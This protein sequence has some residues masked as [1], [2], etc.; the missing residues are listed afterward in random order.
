[1]AT[2]P[3]PVPDPEPDPTPDPAPT[4]PP[5]GATSPGSENVP[6]G[7][8]EATPDPSGATY[9]MGE[10]STPEAP[11]PADPNRDQWGHLKPGASDGTV[12]GAP[13]DPE[14]QEP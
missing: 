5:G 3:D 10:G 4:T 13:H 1:M 8:P 6:E 9:K 7:S 2:D 14:A 12:T 11:Q